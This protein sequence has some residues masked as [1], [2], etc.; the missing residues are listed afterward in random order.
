MKFV[1]LVE[2]KS[3]QKALPRFLKRWLDPQLAFPVRIQPVKFTGWPEFRKKA[4]GRARQ[5]LNGPDSNEIIAAIGLLDLYGPDFYPSTA[6]SAG[7]RLV[8]GIKL[9]ED[10]VNDPR[11]RMFFAVH[12]LEAWI[13]SQ[14][15][16]LPPAVRTALPA[17]VS[18]PESVNFDEPPS[19]LLDRLYNATLGKGYK[20]VVYGANIFAKLDPE[21]VHKKCPKFAA[22]LDT[23]L[24]LARKRQG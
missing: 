2:G 18:Q 6:S 9:F 8:A 5:H 14:P 21:A 23:M 4:A 16:L 13:L 3:E 11:F 20:K 10:E 7:Q 17:R 19:K 12:E 24:E 22:M 1:L 15:E